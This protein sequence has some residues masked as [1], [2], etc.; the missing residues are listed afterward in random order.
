MYYTSIVRSRFG[1]HNSMHLSVLVSDSGF[2]EPAAGPRK[3]HHAGTCVPAFS[4]NTSCLIILVQPIIICKKKEQ[5]NKK[6][7]VNTVTI[8]IY[9]AF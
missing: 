9:Q 7:T 3:G 8:A 5:T 6:T 1:M 2:D 4:L